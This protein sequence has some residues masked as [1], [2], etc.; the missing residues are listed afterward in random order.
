MSS[1]TAYVESASGIAEGARTGIASLV[2]GALFLVA[3]FFSPLVT[4]I[5]YQAAS[6]A[7]VVVGFLMMTQIRLMPRHQNLHGKGP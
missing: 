4:I 1:N 5:P 7:L 6:P 2:T 3:M